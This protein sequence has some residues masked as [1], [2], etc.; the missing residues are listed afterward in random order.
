RRHAAPESKSALRASPRLPRDRPLQPIRIGL[1]PPPFAATTHGSG[2]RH[3]SYLCSRCTSIIQKLLGSPARK[4][5]VE[6]VLLFG[7]TTNGRHAA[8]LLIKR[9]R[10]R[11]GVEAHS[12]V[13]SL[14]NALFNS[15]PEQD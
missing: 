2:D 10:L 8:Y 13:K 9:L 12:S 5:E 4:L 1:R 7:I 14:V 6:K 15:L 3:V 11:Q